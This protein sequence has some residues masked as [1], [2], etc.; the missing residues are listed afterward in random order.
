ML[1][2]ISVYVIMV[3]LGEIIRSK[4]CGLSSV[5]GLKSHNFLSLLIDNKRLYS[6]LRWI[7]LWC[8]IN[9]IYLTCH[10]LSRV[11][12]SWSNLL[13]ATFENAW[14]IIF[15]P[16]IKSCSMQI[17]FKT[18]I[19]F[20]VLT[21]HPHT[22]GILGHYKWILFVNS[23][24]KC[25][26]KWIFLKTP[27][28]CTHVSPSVGDNNCITPQFTLVNCFSVV[29][30]HKKEQQ[31]NIFDQRL[32]NMCQLSVNKY[33]MNSGCYLAISTKGKHACWLFSTCW[34]SMTVL[35]M[36]NVKNEILNY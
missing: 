2:V 23:I 34:P 18:D 19:I 11:R 12:T 17:F 24:C 22:I 21:S 35:R 4:L 28:M 3:F 16:G 15:Y 32:E 6:S 29:S 36:D 25:L 31:Q 26:L 5:L 14:S 20:Y 13:S 10:V 7:L 33:K 8:Y 30:I 1:W 27:I 9:T